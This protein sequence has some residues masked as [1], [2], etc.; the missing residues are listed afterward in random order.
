MHMN[1]S[2][3][4]VPADWSARP[5]TLELGRQLR[6]VAADTPWFALAPLLRPWHRTWGA[7]P[8]EVAAAMPGDELLPHAQY[9]STRAITISARPHDV[10]P[11]LVQVGCR[12]A[13]WYA[14]DLLDNFGRPSSR[15]IIPEL[16]HLAVGQ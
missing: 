13:G 8:A 14:N 1:P 5:E 4:L 16:Q 9:R 7:T 2:S 15:T 3:S 10:W 11:W 6:A 12:R